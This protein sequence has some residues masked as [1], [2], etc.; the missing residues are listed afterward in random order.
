M[1]FFNLLIFTCKSSL[2]FLFYDEVTLNSVFGNGIIVYMYVVIVDLLA[3][4]KMF[5]LYG[6]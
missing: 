5:S 2:F 4:V 1:L 6:R 3:I